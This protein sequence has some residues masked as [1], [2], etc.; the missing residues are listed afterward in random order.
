M[1]LPLFFEDFL[2]ESAQGEGER[3]RKLP[4]LLPLPFF[5]SVLFIYMCAR[6]HTCYKQFR[7]PSLSNKARVT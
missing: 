5:F 1:I 4:I 3:E 7:N 2:P 6:E